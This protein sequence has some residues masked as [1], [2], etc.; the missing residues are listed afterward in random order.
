MKIIVECG[1]NFSTMA[2][3][4]KMIKKAKEINA[5]LCKF[6]IYN[7]GIIKDHLEQEFLKNIMIDKERAKILVDYGKEIGQEV[8][9]SCMT[10][11]GIEW[12]EEIGVHYYKI[13]FFDNR[14]LIL[15]RR[16]KKTK[17][18]IFISCQAPK[19]TIYYNMSKYQKRIKFLYCVPKYPAK[20]NSYTGD[21][22]WYGFKGISDHTPDLKLFIMLKDSDQLDYFE[23][24]VK[25][26]DTIPIEDKWSKTFQE[27][28]EV[29]KSE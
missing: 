1:C 20:L 21:M 7:E 2:E 13:R 22:L 5:F 14:N 12:C 9:F 8:F 6:Q 18:P 10:S 29:L 19:D 4:K 24:H 3:A 23:M 28:N 16:I 26:K 27:L 17:V 25:L 15:Y 11:E